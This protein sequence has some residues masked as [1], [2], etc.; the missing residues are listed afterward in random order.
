MIRRLV[1]LKVSEKEAEVEE[2]AI[3]VLGRAA[4]CQLSEGALASCH[5]SATIMFIPGSSLVF[6]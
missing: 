4:A 6:K 1:E 2:A 3:S 5:S